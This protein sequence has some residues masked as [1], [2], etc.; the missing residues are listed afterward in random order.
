MAIT[1]NGKPIINTTDGPV[2]ADAAKRAKTAAAPEAVPD[3]RNTVALDAAPGAPG[4]A[5]PEAASGAPD[6]AA[7]DAGRAD[8]SQVVAASRISD[9]ELAQAEHR[10]DAQLM[11][12]PTVR[13]RIPLIRKTDMFV[14]VGVNGVIKRIQRGV[15]LE[16]PASIVEVLEH[17]GI[18]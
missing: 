17:A 18:I 9:A 10:A 8:M 16:L 15:T 13:V 3:A 14:D 2:S 5:A 1:K 4:A 6:A 12:E 7:P 11:S